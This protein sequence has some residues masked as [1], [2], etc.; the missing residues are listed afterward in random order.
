MNHPIH[1]RS[2]LLAGLLLAPLACTATQETPT[3]THTM[4]FHEL[5][6]L[7]E[8]SRERATAIVADRAGAAN[9]PPFFAA[10]MTRELG[11]DGCRVV[12]RRGEHPFRDM[13]STHAR[14][15]PIP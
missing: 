8:A 10:E 15:N 1:P 2:L 5:H 7:D 12:W 3:P 13:L 6:A 4:G 9:A 14:K 11:I